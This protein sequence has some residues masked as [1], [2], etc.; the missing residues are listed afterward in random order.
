MF[1]SYDLGRRGVG[2]LGLGVAVVIQSVSLHGL[3]L[4]GT[5]FLDVL[6]ALLADGESGE[7]LA[8]VDGALKS[9]ALGD[10]GE[11]ASGKCVTG[12]SGVANVV[13]VDLVDGESLDV[14]LALD[15][16]DG[17]LGALSDDGNTLALLVL[18]GKVG[19]VL[20]DGGDVGG[21]EVVGLGVGG[22][23]GLVTDDVVPVRRGLVKLVLEELGNE[24]SVEGESEGLMTVSIMIKYFAV[25]KVQTLF[26][27]AASSARAM[28]AGTQTVRW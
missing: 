11:E 5:F 4:W 28:M 26:F 8:H 24:G 1:L 9:L 12:T 20:G 13:L 19:E 25:K 2:L 23:L 10:T 7:P 21:L 18:L 6:G 22:G 17:R 3:S 27:A 14:V 15:G 16:D